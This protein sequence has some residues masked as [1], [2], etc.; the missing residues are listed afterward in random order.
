MN[1]KVLLIR[2][3]PY[4]FDPT[5]YNVQEIGIGKAFCKLGYD[6]DYITV[7]KKNQNTRVFYENDGHKA[8]WIEVP[9]IRLFRMG[10]N[11]KICDKDFLKQY[12][13]IIVREYYQI[14]ANMISKR[15]DNVTLYSGP[16]WNMFMFPFMSY[17]Y[18]FFV[19][20]RMN[21]NIK[22]KLVKSNLAKEFLE[23]KGYT[24]VHNVGVAL[25]TQRFD[26]CNTMDKL[27]GKVVEFM[28][29]NQC[30][31][32]VGSI[33]SNK[34]YPFL[35][36]VYEKL[37]KKYPNLKFVVIGKSH[38]TA[39]KKLLGNN[40]E[41][42]EKSCYENISDEVRKGIYRVERID[43]PQLKYIY[44][45]AKAFLLPSKLEIFGMVLLEAMYLKAPVVTSRNGGSTTLIENRETGKIMEKFDSEKWASAID[46]Y[47]KDEEYTNK[48]VNNAHEL[49]KNEYNW[50]SVV[51]K[52]I[53]YMEEDK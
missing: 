22:C 11:F 31:L 9:R 19:T 26:E 33:D 51:A 25:D 2:T 27:T 3:M 17:V 52:M 38:Q 48:M 46:E 35:L 39:I 53:K 40:D 15:V 30:I 50:D 20:K 21:K 6:Y 32:Y 28:K 44:P 42:Y 10:I 4:D 24:N 47:L 43:N 7:K 23:K 14:M 16:Y 18:D 49:V 8:R 37:L 29:S 34:N 1:K 12:D 5:S 45:L 13:I 36:E 41:S